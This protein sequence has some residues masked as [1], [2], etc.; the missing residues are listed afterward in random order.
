MGNI[1]AIFNL[2]KDV[3]LPKVNG[4][5][6]GYSP[7]HKF[8]N[9]DCLVSGQHKYQEDRIYYPGESI[10]ATITFASWEYISNNIKVG[11]TFE[12]SEMN[13]VVGYGKVMKIL[14]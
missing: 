1:I 4:I 3:S 11:D 7:H 12:V 10:I 9:I 6:T 13:R 8:N 5:K 14:N 2:S